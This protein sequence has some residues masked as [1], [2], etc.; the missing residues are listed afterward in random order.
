MSFTFNG[1]AYTSCTVF[2]NGYIQFGTSTASNTSP[3]TVNR[4]VVAYG[5]DLQ[6]NATPAGQ[7]RY[8]VIG[9]SPN[10][11][12]VIQW[13]NMRN[14]CSTCTTTDNFNF[15][16]R[17]NEGTN[18]IDIVYGTMTST[19]TTPGNFMSS[20]GLRVVAARCKCTRTKLHR[21]LQVLTIRLRGIGQIPV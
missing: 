10:R 19:N 5:R 6:G 2:A 9:S 13:S 12:A 20:V 4:T 18:T 1:T 21:L 16:I 3:L 15:Q 8:E 11:T 14:Y 7:V 17:L